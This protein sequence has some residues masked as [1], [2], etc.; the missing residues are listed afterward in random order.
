MSDLL[1]LVPLHLIVSQIP[2]TCKNK[3]HKEDI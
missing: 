3:P 1:Q 2:N